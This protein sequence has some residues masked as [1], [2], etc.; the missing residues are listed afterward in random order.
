MA[1]DWIEIDSPMDPSSKINT[2]NRLITQSLGD[3]YQFR[4]PDGINSLVRQFTVQYKNI[5]PAENVQMLAFIREHART[6]AALSVPL[7]PEDHT[8]DSKALFYI[9]GFDFGAD[10]GG[11]LYNWTI[12]LQEIFGG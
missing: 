5:S 12:Q 10:D 1:I 2:A 8:G 6:G 9:V 7:L 4:M 11:M 3:G